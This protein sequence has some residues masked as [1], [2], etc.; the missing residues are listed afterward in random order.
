M[1]SSSVQSP[2]ILSTARRSHADV[3]LRPRRAATARNGVAVLHYDHE[4][5]LIASV[6][7]QP[8]RWI[9]P[10]GAAK[11]QRRPPMPISLR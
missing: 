2:S 5:D 10:R 6:T 1:P 11:A 4:Y 3:I 8:T 9:V 7:G